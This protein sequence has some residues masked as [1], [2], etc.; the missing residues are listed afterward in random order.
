MCQP[1]DPFSCSL[2][3]FHCRRLSGNAFCAVKQSTDI[4]FHTRD[5][6][7]WAR[8]S[9]IT[10]VQEFLKLK[11]SSLSLI[12]FRTLLPRW[13]L[14]SSSDL[15]LFGPLSRRLPAF[16]PPSPN[17]YLAFLCFFGLSLYL[18]VLLYPVFDVFLHVRNNLCFV[19]LIISRSVPDV[20]PSSSAMHWFVLCSATFKFLEK[21]PLRISST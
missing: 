13:I 5:S 12:R 17:I 4:T 18:I 9:Y 10:T 16:S 8:Q 6:I 21:N 20:I 3:H 7:T 14:Y 15:R 19:F 1:L 11:P 2:L